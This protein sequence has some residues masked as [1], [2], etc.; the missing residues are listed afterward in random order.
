MQI[1]DLLMDKLQPDG[2]AIV[3]EGSF[4]HALARREGQ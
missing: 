2:L 1:A 4:L 3:M